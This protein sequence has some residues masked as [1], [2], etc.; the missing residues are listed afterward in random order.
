MARIIVPGSSRSEHHGPSRSRPF[1]V[2]DLVRRH[3]LRALFAIL[4]AALFAFAPL[5][6]M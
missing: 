4:V 6:T 3:G 5:A 2:T 1:F